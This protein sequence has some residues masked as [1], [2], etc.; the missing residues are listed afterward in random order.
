M[1]CKIL[2]NL[3]KNEIVQNSQTLKGYNVQ[4]AFMQDI[5]L[6]PVKVNTLHIIVPQKNINVCCKS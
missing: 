4:N 1:H 5:T 2:I 6:I 3:S